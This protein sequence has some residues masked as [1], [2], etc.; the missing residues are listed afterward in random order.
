MHQLISDVLDEYLPD[1]ERYMN[2]TWHLQY[3]YVLLP[4]AGVKEADLKATLTERQWK[5][6]QERDLPDAVQYWEGIKSYHKQRQEQ[7]GN[8]TGGAGIFDK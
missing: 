5:L 8:T 7:G 6:V 3:Y 2:H 1:I 4:L